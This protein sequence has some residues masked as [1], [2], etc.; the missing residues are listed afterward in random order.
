[1]D[2]LPTPAEAIR[3][4][5]ALLADFS[6]PQPLTASLLSLAATED[7]AASLV[8]FSALHHLLVSLFDPID[9]TRPQPDQLAAFFHDSL[10]AA[11]DAA[12]G[13]AD[14][15]AE[16]KAL[17]ADTLI[18]VV[19]QI[20]QEVENGGLALRH[21]RTERAV[22]D[23]GLGED[24][25]EVEVAGTSTAAD[26]QKRMQ[27]LASGG[28][29]RLAK[30]VKQ[31][32]ENGV[33]PK[34][35]VLER[36]D[37]TIIGLLD[38][39]GSA[40]VFGRLEV[41]QRTALY[42]K[43][44]KFNLLRE[45]SEGYSKL[46]VE[47]LSNLGPPHSTLTAQSQETEQERMRRAVSVGDKVKSLIGNFDLDP[48]RT[49]DIFLD[50][51]ADQV[52]EHHQFF[53]DFLTVSP[54][55]P[56]SKRRGAKAAE[57]NESDAKGKSKEVPV[58]VGLED[59]EGS[60]TIAHILGFKFA[61]YQSAEASDAPQNLYLMTSL[62][63]W[64]GFVKLSDLWS[65]LSP[66]DADLL[67]IDAR[68][69]DEQAQLARSV[70][71]A[72]ALAMAGALADDDVPIRPSTPSSTAAAAAPAASSSTAP[73]PP[74]R[75][76][77]NQKLGLLRAL[78]SI[79]DVTHSLFILSQYPFLVPA[80]P[81]LADLLNRLLSVSVQPAYETISI[82]RSKEQW[83][84]ELT[85]PKP[86]FT[87]DSKGEK[88]VLPPTRQVALTGDAFPDPRKDWTFFF[89]AWKE[90][91]PKAG[92]WE[93]VLVVLEK[94]F[95]PFISVFVSRDFTLFTKLC[96]MMVK[97]LSQEPDSP[98]RT[99]WLDLIR[100]F[101]L[102]SISLLEHHTAAALEIWTVLSLF[103]IET[104]FELYGEWKDVWYRR[105]PAL[106]VRKA[107]AERDVK[108]VLRRL[109]TDNVKK[110]GKTFA[111]IAHTNPTV[112]FAVALN[113]V[114]S[115]DN[116]IHPVV[117]A[118]RYLTELGYDV[119]AYS[120]LDSLSS[121]RNKTKE[122]G[123]SV[124]MWLQ[125]VATFTGQLYRRWAPLQGS[126]WVVL[127]YLVNQL[128]SG[129][130]KD[131]VV[132]R[133]LIARMTAIEPFADLSDAQVL[134]LAGGKFLRS[135]VFQQTDIAQAGK[136]TQLQQV[137]NAR[138]RLS[139]ALMEKGLAMPLLVNIALQRQACLKTDAHLKSLGALFDQNHAIL[140]Q[141][142]ELLNAVT[143]PDQ[144]AGM[145]PSVSE[146]METFK[147][148]ASVAFD[149]ARPKLRL[150]MRTHDEQEAAEQEAKKKQGLLAKLAKEK[151]SASPAP[152]STAAAK[153]G[154]DVKMED[155]KGEESIAAT[156]AEPAAANGD[157]AMAD[158]AVSISATPPP[159]TSPWHP[160][161]VDV[162]E[163]AADSLPD[164]VKTSLGAP[165][166]VTFWQ[167]TLYDL[168]Y[169]KERYDAEL[170][171]LQN[172]QR[173]ARA[174]T[175]LRDDDR[176]RFSKTVVDLANKLMD[177]AGKHMNARG[178][179]NR[180][181]NR[182]KTHWFSGVRTKDA[183]SR[184][185]EDILQYCIQPRA[186]LSL[187][188][189]VYAY[190]MIKRLHSMNTPAFHTIVF[191][192]H[193]L[194]S[195]ISPV[196]YSC[197]ENEA[198]NYGRFLYDV[199][200][201]IYKWHKDEK[202][203]KDEAIADKLHGFMRHIPQPG[204]AVPTPADF[205]PHEDFHKAV[206]KWH[207]HM[208]VGFQ[209]S[210]KSGEYMHIKNSILV[211]TKIAPY[212][213]IEH[214]HGTRLE[215]SVS[216][217]IL[218]E[219]R[220]DLKILAQGYKAVL[221]KRKRHWINPP[222]AEPPSSRASAAQAVSSASP[223]PAASP[224]PATPAPPAVP[225]GAAAPSNAPTGPKHVLPIRPGA[226]AV[227][228]RPS[229]LP[230]LSTGDV[231]PS[232][233]AAPQAAV[234][235]SR[236]SADIPRRPDT[237]GASLSANRVPGPSSL[238]VRPGANGAAS[239]QAT[240]TRDEAAEKLRA[241]ALAT[242]KPST[243]SAG[244]APMNPPP[245]PSSSRALPAKPDLSP[246]QSRLPS[247]RASDAERDRDRDRRG[248][249][250]RDADRST[251]PRSRERERDR[252]VESSHSSSRTQRDR[253]SRES[254]EERDRRDPGR[255]KERS[256]RDDRHAGRETR[257]SRD[258]R[259]RDDRSRRTS[260]SHRR[261]DR[262]RRDDGRSRRERDDDRHRPAAVAAE[263]SSSSRRPRDSAES[264]REKEKEKEK[265]RQRQ[266]DEEREK[267][268]EKEKERQRQRDEE[269]EKERE[270]DRQREKERDR[271]ERER[272]RESSRGGRRDEPAP[273][274]GR[275][276]LPLKP[277]TVPGGDR[278]RPAPAH[279][280]EQAAAKEPEP[281]K[282]SLRERAMASLPGQPAPSPPES[283]ASPSEEPPMTI[284]GRGSSRL[285][286]GLT[287]GGG[288]SSSRRDDDS[289]RKRAAPS[290]SLADRL[291][292]EEKRPRTD[293][294][295]DAPRGRGS[296]SRDRGGRR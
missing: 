254:R 147:L 210:F 56:K 60:E 112:I 238:P 141:Y 84:D 189:A 103:P 117:E 278:L 175:G 224:A 17:V 18:D 54:W 68:Y 63:I 70:G 203:Y 50:T 279:L 245:A 27:A 137:A 219:K 119:L 146:L 162:I 294:S 182:E 85:A 113:Q 270:R 222:P 252:S 173:E 235:A 158:A 102:P 33:L 293:D 241:D 115:Y 129:N 200:G 256:S 40:P 159:P 226:P 292:P 176:D 296:D 212:F 76:L 43:Q 167:L 39:I 116:L 264:E 272:A 220:E 133:E 69:R 48:G 207:T 61:Y 215:R 114:Q 118:A 170:N 26:E 9:S 202:A 5:T 186:R 174:S 191:L 88:K 257:S 101:F 139:R 217:L 163:K 132:L 71:G 216:E 120:V 156:G 100:L 280:K 183:R 92:D 64:H 283:R 194:T 236:P 53:I 15:K 199:L 52:I 123:T 81:D 262:D 107:E 253:E 172:M 79:G 218:A 45:E 110:L 91:T 225:A 214:S 269:R 223:T 134:S 80:F 135:E 30:L 94:T 246:R 282:G 49:L 47:L 11:L 73:P 65:H 208:V 150:A 165:F 273:P 229:T 206:N 177:E 268:K 168:I 261:D 196:L 1:M 249:D 286:A 83:I 244:T 131:L 95:M 23:Q 211:L 188:D 7:P 193:L 284:K 276:S 99:R 243:P 74:P 227:S 36:L 28:R 90:R 31:L 195:Q 178:A 136:R 275:S 169:P 185:V 154:K 155:V 171:R 180:R 62:L 111:K 205:Y 166:F 42:Y 228:A 24:K 295:R 25:M 274:S 287:A 152:P 260:D 144:L 138:M 242:M 55:A 108:S 125:G 22:P 181:L 190:Q 255:E 221:A 16:R 130:S 19:W 14:A 187:P 288:S 122:D 140:F 197:T 46:V 201:D 87:V 8:L 82:V 259:D 240:S 37:L 153:D 265:E 96:R 143:E 32:I 285:F 142:M 271:K 3:Q 267:E 248:K 51:F 128:V 6:S 57:V 10:F 160:G 204:A 263:L 72:N 151:A 184:L 59:N 124:A 35:A 78:L 44:Q 258:D 251:R 104:R 234:S 231:Q 105:V 109:S 277:G 192:D 239:R 237:N 12:E 247:P 291:A 121:N 145:V 86:R 58:D 289:N 233:P 127:Q 149:I 34:A 230:R 2:A 164:D 4:V 290:G 89:H 66:N 213:P 75:D 20:D 209:E 179:T 21:R 126:L 77:P 161:L 98:R 250:L 13:D 106:G 29:Q 281:P 41:R 67:K 93:G 148:D 38:Y 97:D 157:A 266:R 198:R 232:P